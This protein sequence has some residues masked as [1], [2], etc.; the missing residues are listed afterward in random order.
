[1]KPLL[2]FVFGSSV[3][4]VALLLFDR[5]AKADPLLPPPP[6]LLPPAPQQH[7]GE[8][9]RVT[10]AVPVGW[11]RASSSGNT[12]WPELVARANSLRSTPGFSSMTYG[13]L[14]PFTASDGNDYAT[15]IEQHY[16]PPE[17]GPKPWGLHHGVTLLEKIRTPAVL[18][19]GF[20]A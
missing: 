17:V 20:W 3:V 13:D 2:N 6:P 12:V 18:S 9:A 1:M 5:R 19:G 7:Y 10:L 14:A 11:R 15:W 8:S 16:H 4:G